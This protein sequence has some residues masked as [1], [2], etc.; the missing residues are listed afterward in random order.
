MIRPK[1]NS[2][3]HQEAVF[4]KSIEERNNALHLKISCNFAVF[5]FPLNG[6]PRNKNNKIR[7][8]NIINNTSSDTDNGSKI[9]RG[10]CGKLSKGNLFKKIES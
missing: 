9:F 6:I 5:N 10:S 7:L 8:A 1:A 2:S 3:A 4:A